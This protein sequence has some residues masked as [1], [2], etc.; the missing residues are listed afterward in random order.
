MYYIKFKKYVTL[1]SDMFSS[2]KLKK[3]STALE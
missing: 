2:S 1:M 3:S